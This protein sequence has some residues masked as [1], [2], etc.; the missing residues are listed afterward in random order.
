MKVVQKFIGEKEVMLVVEGEMGCM[1]VVMVVQD[2]SFMVGFMGMYV[3][4]V[5]IVVVE[6]VVKLKCLLVLFLVVGGVWMQEGILLLMQMFCI[7]VVVEMLKEVCL[8]YIVVLMYL[9]MGGVM[10]FYVMLGDIQI[11]ELNV[12]I[13]FVGLC[14]IEQIICEKLFE[15][16]Q[17]VEYLLEYGMLDR[18]MYCK[19]MCEELVLIL[20]MVG[21][22]L[23]L[24]VGYLFVLGYLV[25]V[26]FELEVV[27]V[28]VEV[29]FV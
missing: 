4:N 11:V 2:F 10:V 13:C 5:I 1:F 6:C 25:N 27:E 9:I 16:F 19:K 12:L 17:C 28:N 15:G 21:G 8:F 22:L 3:G 23:V 24:V 26:L 20:C 7:I 14:V 29:K 18:V